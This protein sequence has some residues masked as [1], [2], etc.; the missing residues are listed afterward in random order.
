[1][2][3]TMNNC[4]IGIDLGST[5]TKAVL[6]DANFNLLGIASRPVTY[7]R[8]GGIVEFNLTNYC[9]DLLEMLSELL[10]VKSITLK[11]IGFTGQ[12]E[13]LVVLDASG[14]PMMNAISWMDERSVKE[15]TDLSKLFSEEIVHEVTGQAAVSPTWPATKILWLKNNKPEIFKNAKT[16][17]LLKDYIV[18]YLTGKKLADMSIAT[19]SL[20][21]DI[22]KKCYWQEMLDAIGIDETALPPLTEPCVEAGTLLNN[23]A[24]IIGADTNAKVNIGTLDHFAGM[25]GTGNTGTDQ[26]TLSMGTV[27]AVAK[28][29]EKGQTLPNDMALHYGYQPD[30]YVLLPVAESGGVSLEW[31][32]RTCMPEVNYKKLNEV[33]EERTEIS[34]VIFLPYINGT[35]APEF[36]ANAT[37]VF[38]GLRQEHDAFDMAKAVIEGVSFLLKKNCDHLKQNGINCNEIL[39]VG[40][41]AKSPTWCQMWADTT[42]M[43][44]KI[45][46]EQEAASLGAAMIAAV[47][48]GQFANYED[49]AG[50]VVSFDAIYQ[51]ADTDKYNHKYARFCKLYDASVTL[52]K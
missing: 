30:T 43:T 31:F 23:I 8:Q 21:F 39:A 41:G 47:V 34:D 40:G 45:P 20:Y 4:Y 44:V 18:Y 16:Y 27:M 11:S 17:M 28:M 13:S 7:E 10:K 42:G 35:C 19:F 15:C 22:K 48:D 25:I 52:D 49:A 9:N 37:G 32:R 14:K 51:P 6:Y 1:M 29:L 33:W 26:M 5:N 3:K 24:S 12:A 46:K 36:D 38:W 50:K 2:E